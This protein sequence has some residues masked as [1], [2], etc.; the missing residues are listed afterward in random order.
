MDPARLLP[1]P[2]IIQSKLTSQAYTGTAQ[3]LLEKE[4]RAKSRSISSLLIE[5]ATFIVNSQSSFV[6]FGLTQFRLRRG[7]AMTFTD[8]SFKDAEE[9]ISG[10]GSCGQ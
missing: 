8:G 5:Q 9:P 4:I 3:F 10:N 2:G 7:M 1:A 6:C